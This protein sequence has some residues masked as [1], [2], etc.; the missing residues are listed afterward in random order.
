MTPVLIGGALAEIAEIAPRLGDP[1]T[2]GGLSKNDRPKGRK[3]PERR[4]VEDFRRCPELA[5]TGG[6]RWKPQPKVR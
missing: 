3:P 5:E 1:H 6:N 2:N 4:K